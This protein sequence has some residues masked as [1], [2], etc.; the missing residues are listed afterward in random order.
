M[1]L[2]V[3]TSGFSY[4][5]WKG[6]FYPEKLKDAE[7]LRYYASR[8]TTV[9]INNTFYRMPTET[10]LDKWAGEVPESF[11]FVL[12]MSQRISHMR[13]LKECAEDVGYFFQTAA[14]LGPRLGPVLIQLPPNF[15][16]DV[17]RLAA[18]LPL[19]PKGA[20]A[21]FEFREPS[22]FDREVYDALKAGGATLCAA[23]TDDSG[24]A[25]PPLVPM[26]DW[27]YLRLRRAEYADADL[28][29]WIERVRSM[30]WQDAFV[31]F[32]HEDAGKGAQFA[33]RF[34]ALWNV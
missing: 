22:W 34:S 20:R 12:K 15:K 18:F 13:R 7:M 23:D 25:G 4:K 29:V 27:G 19:L 26:G 21:A 32:K 10:L 5:E 6:S 14:R 16:K 3:G 11:T 1:R 31:F 24:E 9:E 17:A 28:G 33:E 8:L 2:F 30:P